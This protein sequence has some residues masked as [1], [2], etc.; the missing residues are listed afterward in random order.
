MSPEKFAVIMMFLVMY[1]T[2]FSLWL[3][4]ADAKD[5]L[6]EH[7]HAEHEAVFAKPPHGWVPI[8][9]AQEFQRIVDEALVDIVQMSEMEGVDVVVQDWPDDEILRGKPASTLLL[10]VYIGSPITVWHT[11]AFALPRV[12]KI[13][14]IPIEMCNKTKEEISNAVRKVVLHEVG[15]HMG[16]DHERLGS[17]GL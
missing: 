8:N 11:R 13:F 1:V 9:S 5:W 15:H 4:S 6:N 7:P 14:Q 2:F 16:M 12:I 17:I 3:F 10:G